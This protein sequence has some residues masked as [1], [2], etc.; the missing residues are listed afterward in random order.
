MELFLGAAVGTGGMIKE[1][2]RVLSN[3][4]LLGPLFLPP[5]PHED[6]QSG[7]AQLVMKQLPVDAKRCLRLVSLGKFL[8]PAHA[9]LDVRVC[10]LPM[11]GR[12]A[13]NEIAAQFLQ[14]PDNLRRYGFAK[15][16]VT[17]G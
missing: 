13:I 7:K 3:Q 14:V 1:M 4:P 6:Q 11:L 9:F 8:Q 16:R 2:D 12:E 17:L 10:V 5:L 15:V